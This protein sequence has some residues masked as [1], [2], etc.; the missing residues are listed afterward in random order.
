MG[1]QKLPVIQTYNFISIQ[2]KING[3]L[4]TEIINIT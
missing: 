2:K 3:H 4:M 1:V